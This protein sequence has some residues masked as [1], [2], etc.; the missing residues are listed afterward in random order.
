MLCNHTSNGLEYFNYPGT[1]RINNWSIM[2]NLPLLYEYQF[3]RRFT[4]T[5]EVERHFY[6]FIAEN[7]NLINTR[8][9]MIVLVMCRLY[10]NCY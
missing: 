7:V 2:L 10:L 6:H 8:L 1:C 3:T 4:D 9:I 5:E